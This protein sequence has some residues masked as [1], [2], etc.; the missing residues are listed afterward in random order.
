MRWMFATRTCCYFLAFSILGLY[1]CKKGSWYFTGIFTEILS[2]MPFF[3]I[4]SFSSFFFDPFFSLLHP[5]GHEFSILG[6]EWNLMQEYEELLLRCIKEDLGFKDGKPVAACIIYKCLV[7][8][9]VFEA[10][11]TTIFDYIIEAVNNVIKVDNHFISFH[12]LETLFFF[13]LRMLSFPY[14]KIVSGGQ[15]EWCLAIL[16]VQCFCTFMPPAEKSTIKWIPYNAS[17][18]YWVFPIEWK[19]DTSELMHFKLLGLSL[20]GQVVENFFEDVLLCLC[21]PS[22]STCL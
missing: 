3:T 8:G 10:E 2:F 21:S 4:V 20:Y 1:H 11:R 16:V 18:F 9:R 15:W 7:H 12:I 22:I 19:D 17:I 5:L 13:P 6:S 14:V